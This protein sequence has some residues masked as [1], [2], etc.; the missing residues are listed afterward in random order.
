M[1]RRTIASHLESIFQRSPAMAAIVRKVMRFAGVGAVTAVLYALVTTAAITQ[2]RLDDRVAAAVGYAVL[3]PLN[4]LAHRRLTFQS[5]SLFSA[6]MVR[7]AIMQA[8][9]F[10]M[11]VGTMG[12]M[13]NVLGLHFGFGIVL[14]IVL[15]PILTYFGLDRFVFPRQGPNSRI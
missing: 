2:L 4:F 13:V 6:D 15:A 7:Y 5:T 10:T 14:A 8:I 11:T 1:L 3:L 12:F 9:I